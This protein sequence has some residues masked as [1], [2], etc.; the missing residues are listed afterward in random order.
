MH[1]PRIR[2]ELDACLLPVKAFTPE[3]WMGLRDPFPTWGEQA[4]EAAE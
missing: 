1:E 2:R 3:M 4:L